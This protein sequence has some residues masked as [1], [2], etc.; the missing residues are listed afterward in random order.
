[1]L[2]R[3]IFG[4]KTDPVAG[5]CRKGYNKEIHNFYSSPN[6]IG[7]YIYDGDIGDSCRTGGGDNNFK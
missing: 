2:L 1:M 5:S 3:R 6:V 4:P 7:Y